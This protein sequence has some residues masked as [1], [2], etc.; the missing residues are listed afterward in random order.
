MANPPMEDRE[1]ELVALP[2]PHGARLAINVQIAF[3]AWESP[4]VTNGIVNWGEY[5]GRLYGPRTGIW[6]LVE[7]LEDHGFRSCVHISGLLVQRWPR[8][9]EKLAKN[10]HEIVGHGWA[11]D[12]AM[13]AMNQEQDRDAVRRTSEIVG[14]VTGERPVGWSSH[15]SRRG[16]FT[17][18]SLIEEGYLYTRDFRDADLPYVVAESQGRRLLAMPRTDDINDLPI[19][20]MNG[21]APSVFVDYFRRSFD[22]L[23]AESERHGPQVM[24][25]VT[26]AYIMGRAWGTSALIDCLKHV[27]AHDKVWIC[28]GRQV[29]EHYLKH[30]PSAI[31]PGHTSP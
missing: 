6:R 28:T 31:Q 25:C 9:I 5:S 15:A 12:Q 18:Q 29:A 19:F 7:A 13:H 24:T 30:L 4:P 20:K 26:H 23:Y 22:Q 10:G 14:Q 8:I 11:Q 1:P 21:L 16:E 27:R 17:V 3:E 2:L